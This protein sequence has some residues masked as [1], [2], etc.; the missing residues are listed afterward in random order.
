MLPS[1]F[2]FFF[3]FYFYKSINGIVNKVNGGN[4]G[5][6]V[7]QLFR[8]N[9]VRGRGLLVRAVLQAQ[10]AS[11]SFSNVYAALIAVVN[12]KLPQVGELLV[13][14]LSLAFQKGLPRM[15]KRNLEVE[16]VVEMCGVV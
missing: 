15:D 6:L 2:F 11:P 7:L 1:V 5:P 16:D 13:T 10:Q 12:S 9:L 4:I 8:E 14:R 3:S